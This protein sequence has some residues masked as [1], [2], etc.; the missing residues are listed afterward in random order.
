MV[1]TKKILTTDPRFKGRAV[2][3]L[4]PENKTVIPVPDSVILC[5]GCNKNIYPDT[6]YLIYLDKGELT[7][8]LPY[9]IYCEDCRKRYF[10]KATVL[11]QVYG[12]M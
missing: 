5:N 9:D 7:A 8:D 4:S 2:T 1:Y 10:P 12:E 6:G 3:L 11:V